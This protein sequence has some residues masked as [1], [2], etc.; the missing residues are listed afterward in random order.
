MAYQRNTEKECVCWD[1]G[2]VA[3]GPGCII[4]S[5]DILALHGIGPSMHFE[6][7]L[8]HFYQST[9]LLAAVKVVMRH[10][11]RGCNDCKSIGIMS[12]RHDCCWSWCADM[13]PIFPVVKSYDQPGV[14]EMRLLPTSGW[15][16]CISCHGRDPLNAVKAERLK[17]F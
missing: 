10:G 12:L 17:T 16:F 1:V 3:C 4:A 9:N 7:E 11:T 8:R 14:G 2:V 13:K 15:V 6:I 5:I